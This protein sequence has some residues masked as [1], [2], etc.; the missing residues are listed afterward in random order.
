MDPP[1]PSPAAPAPE[2]RRVIT[3]AL[4]L[5]ILLAA[6]DVLVVSP[7]MPSVVA[8]LGGLALY[9]WVFSA[10]LLASTV[11][12]PIFGRLAD[13]YGR[14][15]LYLF[16]IG[17]F[18]LGSALSGAAWSMGVLV[19][20]RALQGL[21][22]GALLPVTL[23]LVGD[24]YPLEQRARMQGVFAGVWGIASV[25]GP[26][27]G[28]ALV[29]HA[30][31][32]WVFYLNLPFGLAAAALIA[33][34]L[35]EPA[36]AQ[37]RHDL[38][39]PAAAALAFGLT[40]VLA[41]LQEIGRHGM[42]VDPRVALV[43]GAGLA[44]LGVFVAR[45]RRAREPLVD[46]ALLR[47]RIFL[48]ANAG[49]FLGFAALYSAT[50]YVPLLVRGVR[51]GSAQAAGL[52]LVPL[53]LAWVV[54]STVAG[55]LLLRAGYRFTTGLGV[56]LIAGG[57]AG[58]TVLE[59]ASSALHLLGTLAVLGCGMGLAMTGFIV[60]VQAAA[61][62]GRMGIATSSVQFFRTLG[63]AVGVSVLGALLLAGLRAHGVDPA[64]LRGGP[65]Q[66]G[67]AQAGLPPDALMG[68]LHVVFVAGL[69]FAAGGV[70]AGLA[71]PGG[72]AREHAHASRRE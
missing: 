48:A 38:D 15:P 46:R 4:L 49:G 69:L 59:R 34:H 17:S 25:I 12:T 40:G 24:L 30:G 21:G 71:M 60:A 61:P 23:T 31:W 11:T 45:E 50:A 68:A 5:G 10:Y 53:S 33:R 56:V 55:R 8:D 47:Q 67:V 1:P 44:L 7:A 70:V 65:L 35:K 2:S 22:A 18:L 27:V 39:V 54:A 28:G 26:P 52:T 42:P 9:P 32:R 20:M 29:E 51:L 43:G 57:C 66:S 62:P 6:L 63:A 37:R 13:T 16:G 41:A 58:L 72:R 19:A 3:L 64:S 14:R 36:H